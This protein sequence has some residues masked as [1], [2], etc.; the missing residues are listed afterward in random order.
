MKVRLLSLVGIIV[1]WLAACGPATS[2][3]ATTAPPGAQ[4]Q[5]ATPAPAGPKR[6]G[7]AVIAYWQSPV[8]LN[9]YASTQTVVNDVNQ[10]VVE[11]LTNVLPDGTRVPQL[12]KEVPSLQNGGVSQDGKTITYKLKEGIVFSDGSPLECEDVVFTWKFIMTPNTGVTSTAGYRE[13]ENITCSDKYT[14][15]MK[16][17]NVYAPFVTLFERSIIPRNAG[18][19]EDG[20]NWPYNRK[21]VGT[22]PWKI[23]EW[24][25]DQHIVL[26]RNEK[27]REQGKPYLDSLVLRYTPSSEVTMQLLSSGEVDYMWNNTEADIPQL[28]KMAGVRIVYSEGLSTER[29][30]LNLAE[31]KD[32]ADPTKPH[33]ILSDKR[34][35]QAI[36][37]GLNRQRIIDSLLNGK[38]SPGR[39]E[40]VAGSYDCKMQPTP[41]DP[42][43][44]K[45]L[46]DEAGW[47]PGPDGI[48]VKDGLKLNLKFQTTSGNKLREDS[49]VLM[50]EDMKNIGIAL[51]IENAPSAVTIG[52]WDSAAPRA[53]GNFDIVMYTTGP[54]IDPHAQMFA[55]WHSSQIPSE[56]FKS[57]TNI[58]RYNNPKADELL[59]KAAKELDP[60]KRKDYY[61]Q[62][63]QLT[64]EDANMVY[65]YARL[66]I[67]SARNRLQGNVGGNPYRNVGWDSQNWWVDE[68]KK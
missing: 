11:G 62:I 7:K 61:C 49:Q 38:A 57:G 44:A 20:K 55:L 52:T 16:F 51:F 19:L 24:V 37:Y 45:Q 50:S 21:L 64:K 14:V 13:I 33:P 10:Y 30:F 56:K 27:Y 17:K 29:F 36:D 59:D 3:P 47:K 28:E 26:S 12:A 35:R 18:K 63:H 48:R 39:G 67:G 54:S 31:N 42:N 58:T 15:V 34:V 22:G 9:I 40:I 65:V 32:G 2:P 53:R 25:P 60:T 66:G 41:H 8:Q 23:D 4:V 6:G 46:L 1:L 43:K 5:P 68:S